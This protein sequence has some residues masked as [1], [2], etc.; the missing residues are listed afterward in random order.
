MGDCLLTSRGQ[1]RARLML[2][3]LTHSGVAAS[4]V[5]LPLELTR[6]GCA[7]AVAIAGRDRDRALRILRAAGLAPRRTYCARPTG[8]EVCG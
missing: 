1:T 8:W 6:E 3:E 2:G 5:R 7:Y 4:L